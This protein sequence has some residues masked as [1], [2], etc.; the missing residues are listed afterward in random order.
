VAGVCGVVDLAGEVTMQTDPLELQ[1][2][3]DR[4]RKREAIQGPRAGDWVIMSDGS[5]LRLTGGGIHKVSSWVQTNQP[6][7]IGATPDRKSHPNRVDH[8]SLS[9]D[10]NSNGRYFLTSKGAI[11]FSGGNN[12]HDVSGRARLIDTQQTKPGEFSAFEMDNPDLNNEDNVRIF[13][14]RGVR[15]ELPCRVY[16]L[17]ED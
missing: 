13:G 12:F 3:Q 8:P 15:F 10:F 2:I 7:P 5:C 1:V 14:N 4:V 6:W 11:S 16:R 17:V 9:T